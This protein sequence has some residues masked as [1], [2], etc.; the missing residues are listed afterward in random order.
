M[1]CIFDLPCLGL[2]LVGDEDLM[3]I[4]NLKKDECCFFVDSYDH[5]YCL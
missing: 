3:D 2:R 1:T 5:D 4:F